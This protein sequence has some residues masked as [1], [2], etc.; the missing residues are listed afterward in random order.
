ML[1]IL[2][3]TALLA[4]CSSPAF[5]RVNPLPQS[6]NQNINVAR[7]FG[8][9][10][11]QQSAD[12]AQ[13]P[14]PRHRWRHVAHRRVRAR[15]YV[16]AQPQPQP[17]PQEQG[18]NLFG[19][20]F[21]SATAPV[22]DERVLRVAEHY[23]GHGNFTGFHGKW[24]AAAT[25]LW[26]REAGYTRLGSLAAIDYARYGRPST[27]KPGVVAVLPHHIGIVAKVYP[28]SILLL[29]GN[30]LHNVGYGVVSKRSI[31]AFRAPV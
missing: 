17:Q 2:T 12:R 20:S 9:E 1:K 7:I 3:I 18:W 6:S 30:H 28:T 8:M 16:R 13:A 31:V 25:G 19:L 4:A 11:Q 21:Y 23:V 29:S 5:A 24:C 14:A 26:L 22:G 15:V 10:V 27:P